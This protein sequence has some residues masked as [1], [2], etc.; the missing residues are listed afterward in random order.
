MFRFEDPIYLYALAVI[1]LLAVIRLLMVSQ[2]KRRLRRFGDK[3][4]MR[5]LTPDV[6]RWRPLVKFYLLLTA[7]ALVIVMLARP[8]F[9]TKISH[10]KRTGIETIIAIDVSNSMLAE[11]VTP[12]RLQRSKMMVENLVDN[13][14]NDKIGLIVFAGNAYIQLPITSDYV[15]AKIFLSSISPEMIET[16]GTDVAA[17]IN[18]AA[19]SF[20]QEQNI[21]K[22]IIVITDGE[23]HEGG[24]LE[25]AKEAQ[26]RG[27]RVYVLGVGSPKGAPIPTG[28]GDFLRDNSGQTVMTGLNE[29]MCRQIAQAGGGAYI[30][31]EN[32]SSAQDQLDAEL[33]KLSKK[34]TK[35]TIFSDYDEQFQAVGII[36]LLLLILEVCIL[37]VKNPMLRSVSLFKRQRIGMTAL[38]TA[39]LCS[40]STTPATAQNDRQLVRQGNKQFRQGN[41]VEAETVYRKAA[42]KNARNPQACY[43]LGNALLAQQKDSAAVSQLQAAAKLETNPQRRAQAYHNIGVICQGKRM[44]GEA[45]EAYKEALRNNPADDATRYNLELCKRQQKEQQNQQN[46]DNKDKKNQQDQDKKEQ[47]KQE[48][49]KKEEQKKQQ[50]QQQQQ[51]QQQQMSRENAEQ[52]LNA[53]I[54]EEKQTQERMKRAQ[55]PRRR[56][57]E[58]NW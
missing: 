20:T 44:F 29:E 31:V 36:V 4:L 45:I 55:Q 34:E 40:L 11:D 1:P 25:A 8:Q 27:M 5:Q 56:S 53:A 52:M 49:Q 13:F 18:M 28:D 17:A 12:S 58:K 33:D 16:Q 42:E 35:S 22:A 14:T 26:A 39:M 24:A 23:D 41:Y 47:Q 50:E 43:N 10:E 30:H 48:Q 38:L 37:E 9:G 46:K 19:N 6:S 3:E 2:Q 21:G 51:Q 7:L 57:L 15:S 32:N 54:Q